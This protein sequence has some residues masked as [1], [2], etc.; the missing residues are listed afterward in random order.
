M[1]ALVGEEGTPMQRSMRR[2]VRALQRRVEGWRRSGGGR[3]SRIPEGL[4]QEAVVLARSAG[5]HATAKVLRLNYENLKKRVA[6][7]EVPA[8]GERP[9]FVSFEVPQLDAGAGMVIELVGGDGERMRIEAR[10]GSAVD[11]VGIAEGFWR[12]R[13]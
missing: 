12:R 1:L 6:A 13:S 2:D 8:R 3:G 5:L 11:V 4:W 7:E 9:E 10:G